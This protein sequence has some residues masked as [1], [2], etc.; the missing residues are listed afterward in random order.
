M[1]Q[2]ETANLLDDELKE[3][4]LRSCEETFYSLGDCLDEE[5]FVT[6]SEGSD[7]EVSSTR[8]QSFED[9]QQTLESNLTVSQGNSIVAVVET[10]SIDSFKSSVY[11]LAENENEEANKFCKDKFDMFVAAYRGERDLVR[12]LNFESSILDYSKRFWRGFYPLIL[13]EMAETD[14]VRGKIA[15]DSGLSEEL[16]IQLDDQFSAVHRL[17]FRRESVSEVSF[18]TDSI[19]RFHIHVKHCLKIASLKE[20]RLASLTQTKWKCE[21]PCE[22]TSENPLRIRKERKGK[23]RDFL[24]TMKRTFTVKRR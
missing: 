2:S 17:I 24:K 19:H 4:K 16:V 12:I 13:V 22:L 1:Q 14:D 9:C 21:Q 15:A 7:S 5:E 18:L 23:R 8:K 11:Y 3:N 20:K 6:A 10:S